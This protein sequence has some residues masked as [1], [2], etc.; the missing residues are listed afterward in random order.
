MT[1]YIGRRGPEGAA[2]YVE[3]AGVL[4]PLRHVV[5]HSPSGL[6]W[7]YGGSGPA[8]L[9]LSILADALGDEEAARPLY[10]AFKREVVATLEHEGW[11]LPAEQVLEWAR[12]QEGRR[13][14]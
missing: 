2:V 7:G 13:Q 6:E 10:Q 14:R 5:C 3:E 12:A 9:A 4:R 8:D 1:T 11:R